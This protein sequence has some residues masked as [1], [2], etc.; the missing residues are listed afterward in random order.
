M[1]YLTT[2]SRPK[3]HSQKR[4]GQLHG[5]LFSI[6][7]MGFFNMQHLRQDITSYSLC[8]TSHGELAGTRCSSMG[9]QLKIDPAN[10]STKDL[11]LTRYRMRPLTASV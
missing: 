8:Y 4:E 10:H 7:S 9:P 5:L 2:H 6:S 3:D 11:Q 1:F